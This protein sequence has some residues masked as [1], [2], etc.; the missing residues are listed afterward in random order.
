M[1]A[2][3][4]SAIINFHN[5]GISNQKE[6]ERLALLAADLDKKHF[7]QYMEKFKLTSSS[8][9]V[10][11]AK[12]FAS[13][14]GEFISKNISLFH[15]LDADQLASVAKVAAKQNPE[16]AYHIKNYSGKQFNNKG[17]PYRS[18]TLSD[19]HLYEIGKI[20]LT[21]DPYS[22]YRVKEFNLPASMLDNLKK[23]GTF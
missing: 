4:K 19:H 9:L 11:I 6:R 3:S 15:M 1:R 14:N 12:L 5:Y 22:W 8:A 10:S 16:A 18:F 2:N 13:K 21:N 20:A 23:I 7:I 17:F